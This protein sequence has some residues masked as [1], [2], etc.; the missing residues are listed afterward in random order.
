MNSAAPFKLSGTAHT[1]DVGAMLDQMCEHFVEHAEVQRQGRHAFFTSRSGTASLRAEGRRILIDLASPSQHALQASRNVIAE[2]MFF[3]A[4]DEPFDLHWATDSQPGIL[5]N[6]HHVTVVGTEKVTP[7]M[8]R[9]KFSCA[10]VSPFIGGDMHVRL[11]VPPA[12]RQPVW[13]TLGADGR[14]AWPGGD[15]TLLVRAYT[16]RKVDVGRGELWIDFFQHPE[17]GILTPGADFARDAL[18]G[19]DV[20]LLGPGS[21]HLPQ[22]RRI[23]LAGD[24][25][26]LPAIARIAEE[27]PAGTE[28]RVLIEVADENEEQRLPG[29][30]SLDIRWLHRNSGYGNSGTVLSEEIKIMIET[31]DEDWFVW[32]ACEKQD[33]RAVRNL[34]RK[35]G[36]DRRNMYV[37]WY[38]EHA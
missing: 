10:D 30:G 2:H 34:L 26:A 11:L 5:T 25:S 20:A 33:V 28:L 29:A 4:G 23:F 3:F 13:P 27:V 9:V 16:I 18:P 7:L 24:E 21:G 1:T 17:P 36:H 32:V 8:L 22:A 31:L 15:D 37:A 12:G 6:L 35:R 19:M 14:V 38:W